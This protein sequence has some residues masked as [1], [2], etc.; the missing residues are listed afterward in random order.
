MVRMAQK[1]ELLSR[2]VGSADPKAAEIRAARKSF[3]A[4]CKLMNPRFFR[5]DRPHLRELAETLQ[6]LGEGRLRAPDG[7][8]C[9]RLAIS[10][11][12]RHGKS[13]TMTLFNQWCF[14]RNPEDR[15]INVSYN[16]LLSGRFS[17]GVRDGID[18]TKI[19]PSF[20]VFSDVFPGVKIKF[21]DSAAQLW[22]LEGSYF[23]F[24]GAGMGG[25]IT[26]VGCRKLIIDDPIKNHIEANNDN[27]LN[28]Q[29]E[30]YT[31]TLLSRVEE[32]GVIILIMTRWNTR[33]L[34]GRVLEAE[35]GK[36][37]V[38]N[39][40]A[41]LDEKTGRMLCPALL[42]F[43]SW[44]AKKKLTSPEI[45]AANYQNEPI[46]AQGRLYAGFRTYDAPPDAKGRR[47]AYIDTADTG[48]DFLCALVADQIDGEGY[49]RDIVYTDE[50]M[51]VTEPLVARMLYD[52]RVQECTIESNNGGRGFAR[53][54]ERLLWEKY[55]WRG[56]TVIWHNQ[57]QN[58]MA[59][60]LTESPF[61]Q[62]HLYYPE[63][64]EEKHR[65]YYG[66][67]R[68]FQR[69]GKNAHDD[70]PDATTGLAEIIQ[71]GAAVRR[72]FFSGRGTR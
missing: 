32:D 16:E 26:G 47:I 14:G 21:G 54:V 63:G 57:R 65:A 41:C 36:W 33:D 19:D 35:P 72:R 45:F 6:A 58:K 55:R 37:H 4:Y 67:M 3:W 64:W 52:Q 34:V 71:R 8:V 1:T 61:V 66:A 28:D 23:S 38:L 17:K 69:K 15:I 46:D 49:I 68:N 60:I 12:P 62:T 70:A 11:P 9:R 27:V 42:S 59:R 2:L 48:A 53:N 10:E 39:H 25:T 56:T 51:E 18:A 43:D 29:W 20:T 5:D 13:Y 40:K 50:P 30:Y 24:L 31:N 22:S 7:S 44:Q